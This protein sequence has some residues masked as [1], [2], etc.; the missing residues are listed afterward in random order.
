MSEAAEA[1]AGLAWRL[2]ATLEVGSILVATSALVAYTARVNV[3]RERRQRS[4]NS[5]LVHLTYDIYQLS[6][7]EDS[8]I[9]TH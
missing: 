1:G 6:L 4:L 2:L 7:S 3:A 9:F 8:S 5:F